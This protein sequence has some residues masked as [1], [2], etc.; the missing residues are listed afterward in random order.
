MPHPS[1]W[2]FWLTASM[3][4]AFYGV[5]AGAWSVALAGLVLMGG[6]LMGWFWPREETQE[7]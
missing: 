2:P 5:L 3:L 7:T 1:T 4:V 6:S